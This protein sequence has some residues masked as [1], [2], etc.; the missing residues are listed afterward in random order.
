MRPD[1]EDPDKAQIDGVSMKPVAMEQFLRFS[2]SKGNRIFCDIASEHNEDSEYPAFRI[3]NYLA[4]ECIG[5][6]C[7][8]EFGSETMFAEIKSA[9]LQIESLIDAYRAVGS[10]TSK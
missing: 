6:E 2:C 7:T 9:A 3:V 1:I 4:S 8:S 5:S 10:N